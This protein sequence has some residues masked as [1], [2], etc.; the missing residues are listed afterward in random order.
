MLRAPIA[1]GSVTNY[2]FKG[3]TTYYVNNS[4]VILYGTNVFEGGTVVKFSGSA[5]RLGFLGSIDCRTSPY[6]PA[7]FTG[8]DDD[9]VGETISGST[10]SPGTN[11]YGGRAFD[12]SAANTTYD[13]HDLHFR[14]P[15]KAIYVA[16]S[17]VTSL[18]SHVQVGYADIAIQNSYP[19][20]TAR[21]L[22][23]HDSGYA[24]FSSASTGT[25]RLENVTSHRVG[26]LCNAG[27]V[28]LT[29]SLLICVT[30]GMTYTGANNAT[31]IDDTGVFQTVGTATHYLAT[32]STNRNAGT[33][34]INPTL[35]ADLKK[36]T[37]YPPI[38]IGDGTWFTNSL[39]LY[40]QAQRD[41]D[42]PD[43]GYHYDCLDYVFSA[44]ALTN[45]TITAMPGVAIG[46]RTLN[47]YGLGLLGGAKFF[48]EGTP[49]NLNRIVRYNMV[50][51]QSNTNWTEFA[52]G[53]GSIITAWTPSSIAP[54][55]RIRF[56]EWSVPASYEMY[57]F[58]GYSEDAGSHEFR[59][60][61]FHSGILYVQ[62]ASIGVTNCLFNR[63]RIL[64]EE[65]YDMNPTFRNCTLVGCDLQLAHIGS[66]TWTFQNNLFD[67][68]TN[69]YVTGSFT[70][71][72]NA[73]TTN[74]TRLTPTNVND[75]RLSVTNIT[76][77]T[78]WLGR[79]YLP[80]NLA[81]QSTLFNK[82]STNAQLLTF[83]HYTT[84]TN[85]VKETN[86][87]VDIGFHYVAVNASGQPLDTD[88]DGLADYFED[89]N[90]N[91]SPDSG[92]T[93][94]LSYNSFNGITGSPGLQVF[95]P[96]R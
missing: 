75:V 70:N 9:T 74:A 52:S 41:T 57:H 7:I 83:Y 47:S 89:T 11:R 53:G 94:W 77:N 45:A 6:R 8:K 61:Q 65:Y 72:Y 54:Y 78:G 91:G 82:G 92:E 26:Y 90:G 62:H 49:D 25:N 31:N 87:T 38:V 60:C 46:T 59:D 80:T 88:G 4:T 13:L 95:T 27:T 24:I 55:A 3:D 2:V 81:S 64:L 29:N 19:N 69:S 23:I 34:N 36:R 28:Y 1:N 21:N 48:C 79:F 16:S 63:T 93:D 85:Q 12:L 44:L 18:L 86:S 50:Q 10:G 33:T 15:Y 14:Y 32:G 58:W 66:G 96:L 43:L 37:T 35:L 73:Y 68:T 40:P 67:A 20:F 5:S 30:N 22:L 56:T 76:Y 51:E 42:T 39:T 71:S 84:T 17:S